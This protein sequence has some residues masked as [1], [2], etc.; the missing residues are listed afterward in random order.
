[1]LVHVVLMRLRPG[2]TE[3]TLSELAHRVSDTS[4]KFTVVPAGGRDAADLR[5]DRVSGASATNAYLPDGPLSNLV[6]I[7]LRHQGQTTSGS[8]ASSGPTTHHQTCRDRPEYSDVELGLCRE[9][10]GR[11]RRCRSCPHHMF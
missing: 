9:L 4:G 7:Q 5:R 6:G 1:M 2:I 10:W 8:P 3:S 11:S